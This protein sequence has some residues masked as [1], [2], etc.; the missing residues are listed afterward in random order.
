MSETTIEHADET[1]AESGAPVQRAIK[2]FPKMQLSEHTV[3]NTRRSFFLIAPLEMERLDLLHPDFCRNIAGQL[4]VEDVI[5]VRGRDWEAE[6]RV[7]ALN[8]VEFAM[9]RQFGRKNAGEGIE[10]LS[11]RDF[12]E[13]RGPDKWCWMQRG[14]TPDQPARV[15]RSGFANAAAA[16]VAWAREQPRR[17]A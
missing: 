8:P 14:R 10:T 12:I 4:K 3:E 5:Y 6:L 9:A 15:H 2:P 13:Y 1:E 11:D 16:R 17:V 7:D